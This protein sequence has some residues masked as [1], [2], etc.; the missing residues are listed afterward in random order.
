MNPLGEESW[1][2]L[3]ALWGRLAQVPAAA[4]ERG[5]LT[6]IEAACQLASA[7]DAS[8]ILARHDPFLPT[9][10]PLRGYRPL[11]IFWPGLDEAHAPL[12]AQW[13][14][15]DE[16]VSNDE[17]NQ[18]LIATL[19]APR[20]F[21]RAELTS[22]EA[23]AEAPARRMLEVLGIAHRMLAAVPLAPDLELVVTID[24]EEGEDFGRAECDRVTAFMEG[25]VP[26][27]RRLAR[28][29]GHL[30]A[31]APLSPR[32][33]QVLSRL[34]TPASEKEIAEELGIAQ[35]TTHSYVNALFVKFRVNS[36]AAMM[37]LWLDEAA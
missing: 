36:R 7:D 21:H 22:P 30:D 13:Q 26:F 34:L 4:P 3:H 20:A 17:S 18:K 19:G 8:L 24:R 2:L 27:G 29:T 15:D 9:K 10:D 6:L 5:V 11:E 32:E 23:W 31:E 14:R 25:V 1:R 12:L 35:S 33:R 28:S 37:A 16:Q